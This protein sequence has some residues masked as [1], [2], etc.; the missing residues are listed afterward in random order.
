[1]YKI[2]NKRLFSSIIIMMGGIIDPLHASVMNDFEPFTVRNVSEGVYA[3]EGVT[4]EVPQPV[5]FGMEKID[6]SNREFLKADGAYLGNQTPC[7]QVTYL[8]HRP[9]TGRFHF[10]GPEQH[11]DFWFGF[12]IAEEN[13]EIFALK[14]ISVE[15]YANDLTILMLH[16]FTAAAM[17]GKKKYMSVPSPIYNRIKP[18][19]SSIGAQTTAHSD[20]WHLIDVDSLASFYQYPKNVINS[21]TNESFFSRISRMRYTLAAKGE[22]PFCPFSIAGF[23][24]PE[25]NF[26]WTDG[27]QANS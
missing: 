20:K 22:A 24:T 8:K 2:V 21:S 17:K 9:T 10:G 1:M 3:G 23:S 15:V 7:T 4:Y 6:D 13:D 5:Y 26:S 14:P 25:T 12:G 16:G 18:Y 19:L 11:R 27:P